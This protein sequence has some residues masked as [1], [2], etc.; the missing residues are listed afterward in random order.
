M[1]TQ[2][3]R[4]WTATRKPLIGCLVALH[5]ALGLTCLAR[6]PSA[7][8]EL[9]WVA[10]LTDIYLRYDFPQTW[11]MFAPPS[12]TVDE[13]G[14]ALQFADGWSQIVHADSFIRQ[15]CSGGPLLPRGCIRLSDQF[16]HPL[17]KNDNRLGDDIFYRHYF[18][19]L[20]AFFCFGD[21]A[22]PGLKAIRFYSLA[23]GVAPFFE[24]NERGQAQPQADAFNHV[25]ALYQRACE[26]R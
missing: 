13:I 21:G 26:D 4:L 10:R 22:I 16:R 9:P 23:T 20:S 17:L 24:K 6:K 18:Q 11:R 3:A 14:Y 5:F 8:R 19:Q 2:I 7:L 12:Q 1:T 15:Y 25:T